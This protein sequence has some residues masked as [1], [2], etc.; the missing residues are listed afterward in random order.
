MGMCRSLWECCAQALR[1][2]YGAMHLNLY[3]TYFPKSPHQSTQPH[4]PCQGV[5]ASRV[6]CRPERL[7]GRLPKPCARISLG[8]E[9]MAQPG[10]GVVQSQSDLAA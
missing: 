10:V 8:K 9:G 4:S 6:H 7:R 1:L 3:S 5:L 2:Q